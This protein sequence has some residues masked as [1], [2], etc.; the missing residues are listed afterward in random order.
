[1]TEADECAA[2]Q[3]QLDA[4]RLECSKI[5]AAL[6]QAIAGKAAAHEAG[7]AGIKAAKAKLEQLRAE[8]VAVRRWRDARTGF[9]VESEDGAVGPQ[10]P[11]MSEEAKTQAKTQQVAVRSLRHELARWKHQVEL[12]EAKRPRQEDEI[13]RLKAEVTHTL[14]IL[15]ST[16]HAVKHHEVEREFQNPVPENEGV[17]NGEVP[18]LGG[19]H[20]CVEAHAE[21]LVR[22]GI[23]DKNVRLSGKAKRL[24]GVVAAQQLLIQRLEKQLLQEEQHLEQKDEHL[25][26]QDSRVSQLKVL[27]RKQSDAH[28]KRMLGVAEVQPN[29]R[30][31]GASSNTSVEMGMSA[32]TPQLPP[33]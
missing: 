32:S 6:D 8:L 13:I 26:F 1:V 31:G 4:K 25:R 27:S 17:D 3:I 7:L 12:I 33:I 16:Q 18:L 5:Q 22:E 30:M 21:R 29:Q 28:V 20:A 19:G 23:E 24:T 2:L 10:A 11:E 14:D 15:T 9:V